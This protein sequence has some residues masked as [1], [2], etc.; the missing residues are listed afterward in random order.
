[1]SS[2]LSVILCVTLDEGDKKNVAR[3]DGEMWWIEVAK[4]SERFAA[5]LN[6]TACQPFRGSL[7]E[8]GNH[9]FCSAWTRDFGAF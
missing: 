6:K 5:Q 8:T 3:C 2:F 9:V 7:L 1:M 4:S